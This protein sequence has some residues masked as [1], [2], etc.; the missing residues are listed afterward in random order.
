MI[1]SFYYTKADGGWQV[2]YVRPHQMRPANPLAK[3]GP[4]TPLCIVQGN[5][6]DGWTAEH[7]GTVLGP[8]KRR[9][10]AAH[11][12]LD[13]RNRAEAARLTE[14]VHAS[15]WT[16]PGR[17]DRRLPPWAAN[18]IYDLLVEECGASEWK[19]DRTSFIHAHTAREYL[20]HEYRFCGYL[21]FGG[22]FW[23][24]SQKFR[25][26]A[27]SENEDAE[28]VLMVARANERLQRLF[29][30]LF[31]PGQRQHCPHCEGAW[32]G[33]LGE[34]C[35]RCFEPTSEDFLTVEV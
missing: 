34:K 1:G 15:W 3:P 27:Y 17:S 32:T 24:E 2:L 7:E 18:L 33:P 16:N 23:N 8:F 5:Q 6:H 9:W 11:A 13:A 12:Y 22:K 10:G 26:S 35:P 20:G 31:D 14:P 19:H 4:G 25:V 21:G 28:V 29:L 30:A